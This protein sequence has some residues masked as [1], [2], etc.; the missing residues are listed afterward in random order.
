MAIIEIDRTKVIDAVRKYVCFLEDGEPTDPAK[1]AVWDSRRRRLHNDVGFALGLEKPDDW[2]SSRYNRD[3]LT[4]EYAKNWKEAFDTIEEFIEW[5]ADRLIDSVMN[6][7]SCPIKTSYALKARIGKLFGA[8]SRRVKARL[9][10][11][12]DI[13]N[14]ALEDWRAWIR[15]NDEKSKDTSIID[16][17]NIHDYNAISSRVK[18]SM[19]TMEAFSR[20]SREAYLSVA[21]KTY[22]DQPAKE[23]WED[24]QRL[25]G[26]AFR[27]EKL[28][29]EAPFYKYREK[30]GGKKK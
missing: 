20:L 14:A 30:K 23:V 3:S 25:E 9:K 10:P 15:S 16:K 12:D 22:Y 27:A 6:D 17:I 24:V 13:M 18:S 1:V 19:S 7:Y 29:A 4:A 28:Y 5:D 21:V 11:V 26:I 8:F 2:H